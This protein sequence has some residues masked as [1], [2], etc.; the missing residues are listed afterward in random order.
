MSVSSIKSQLKELTTDK[1]KD[2]I[3]NL[4]EEVNDDDA[5]NILAEVVSDFDLHVASNLIRENHDPTTLKKS[6]LENYRYS[7]GDESS[8]HISLSKLLTEVETI[9]NCDK[10]EDF[11]VSLTRYEVRRYTREELIEEN[12]LNDGVSWFLKDEKKRLDDKLIGFDVE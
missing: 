7:E 3:M 9:I 11:T 8:G 4:L 5:R 2:K 1:L 12:R 6:S 10:T